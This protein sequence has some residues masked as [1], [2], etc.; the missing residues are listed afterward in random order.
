MGSKKTNTTPTSPATIATTIIPAAMRSP[1]SRLAKVAMSLLAD[2]EQ[3]T[4]D[5][6]AN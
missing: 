5:F 4:V 6:Q 1:E 3:E 2:I